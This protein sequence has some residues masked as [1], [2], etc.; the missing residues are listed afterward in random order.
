MRRV[1]AKF[2][3]KLL[4][5]EQKQCCLDITQ[6]MLGNANSD[7]NYLKTVITRDETWV[8]GYNPEM[9]MQLSEWKHLIS[10]RGKKHGRSTA[11]SRSC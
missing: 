1:S 10:P 2:V 9:K 3:P 11:L 4:R 7:P 5:M 6:D 8:Y